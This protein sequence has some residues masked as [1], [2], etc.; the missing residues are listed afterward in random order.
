MKKRFLQSTVLLLILVGV[1]V[2]STSSSGGIS[3]VHTTGCTC[4]GAA[5]SATTVTVTGDNVYY[6]GD[7]IIFTVTVAN[8]TKA[9]GGFNLKCNI[10]TIAL[11]GT[12]VT[13]V[14]TTEIRHNA[15]RA[16]TGGSASWTFKWKAPASGS[17]ALQFN[18]AGNAVNLSG[19]TSGDAYNFG[20]IAPIPLGSKLALKMFV[21]GFYNG[22]GTMK[23]VLSNQ[24]IVAPLTLTDTV[25]LRVH[26][27]T[28]PYA[29]IK[30]VK[31]V[32]GTNGTS[33]IKLGTLTAGNYYLSV[34]HRN[35]VETWSGGAIPMST[36]TN[37]DF[38]TA[39]NK[40]YASNQVQVSPGVWAFFSGDID[41]LGSLD[42]VDFTTWEM[43]VNNFASGY[44]PSDLD[45]GGSVESA[46]YTIWEGNA[47]N[48]VG[49]I[50]P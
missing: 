13:L 45:G 49:A 48:F 4:H 26:Q 31:T 25:T 34:K 43:D 47:N 14:S 12:G 6:L 5:T 35:A 18:V 42:A 20:T 1:Y 40:A 11:Q 50:T 10:G 3:N 9:A 28:T 16:F 27:A 44:L 15:P 30:T 24:G 36:S 19:N 21:E 7:S 17:T 32:I 29:A 33:N 39:A 23:P 2:V 8:A 38:S 41:Q 22:A 46:D 37:Y